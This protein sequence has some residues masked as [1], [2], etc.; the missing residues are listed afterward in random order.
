MRNL[1]RYYIILRVKEE[2]NAVI[3]IDVEK[4]FGYIQHPLLMKTLNLKII[5]TVLTW[6]PHMPRWGESASHLGSQNGSMEPFLLNTEHG[7]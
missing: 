5:V 7:K 1:L 3:S 4:V 2:K 6:K